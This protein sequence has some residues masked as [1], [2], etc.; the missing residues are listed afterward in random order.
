MF[1]RPLGPI[2]DRLGPLISSGKPRNWHNQPKFLTA[3]LL[4]DAVNLEEFVLDSKLASFLNLFAFPNLT[5]F[6]L[7]A[8]WSDGIEASDLFD[9]LKGSPT[10]RT[11]EVQ[12]SGGIILGETPQDMVTVL[13]NVETFSLFVWNPEPEYKLYEPIARISCPSAKYTSLTQDIYD[14]D[15]VTAGLEMF[16]DPIPWQEITRQ[17]GSSP[18]EEVT[19][20]M[21]RINIAHSLVFRTSDATVITLGCRF[22]GNCGQRTDPHIWREEIHLEIFSQ[23]CRTIQGHPLLS[24]V[25]RLHIEDNTG[26]WSAKNLIP[27]A[28]MAGDLF[29][30]LGPLDEL[31]IHGVDLQIFLA[32]FVGAPHFQLFERVFPPVKELTISGVSPAYTEDWMDIIVELAKSQH[33]LGIPFERVTVRAK[34]IPADTTERLREWVSAVNCCEM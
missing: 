4:S 30:S 29:K 26:A 15:D 27:A 20:K 17:Y 21:V 19:L 34:E 14:D 18:V 8:L 11:V 7:L 31:T 33:E 13:P 6:K 12:L 23:A 2:P 22:V 10:L 28:K 24:H 16:P 25:K 3:P 1:P 5:T 9:F 32:P